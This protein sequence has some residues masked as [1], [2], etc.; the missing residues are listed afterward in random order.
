MY[1]AYQRE[2]LEK[3]NPRATV[4]MM[5][6]LDGTPEKPVS[7]RKGKLRKKRRRFSVGATSIGLE[8]T[9]DC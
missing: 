5:D 1:K 7:R 8:R 4:V 9:R 2:L 3:D 6:F